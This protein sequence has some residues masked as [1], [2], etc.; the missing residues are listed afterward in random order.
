MPAP[1]GTPLRLSQ[2]DSLIITSDTIPFLDKQKLCA[3]LGRFPA[4][5]WH[6]K[7]ITIRMYPDFESKWS[8]TKNTIEYS[9]DHSTRTIHLVDM[10]LTRVRLNEIIAAYVAELCYGEKY[11]RLIEGL[12][13][14]YCGTYYGMP[15]T[16]WDKK[17]AL[18]GLTN[19]ERL[20]TTPE[21]FE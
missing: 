5:A 17:S 21:N 13:I 11:P 10:K 18:L 1:T 14:L 12:A 8:A 16:W 9:Y 6:Q 2:L 19:K 20:I 7:P 15:L 3:I 4:D